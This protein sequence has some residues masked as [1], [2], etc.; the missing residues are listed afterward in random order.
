MTDEFALVLSQLHGLYS[1]KVTGEL[2]RRH[3]HSHDL[4]VYVRLGPRRCGPDRMLQCLTI[5]DVNVTGDQQQKGIF[6]RLLC[7]LEA[8]LPALGLHALVVENLSNPHLL[9]YLL[10]QGYQSTGLGETTVFKERGDM[11]TPEFCK[12][13][14]KALNDPG[15]GFLCWRRLDDGT[16]IALGRL[17][18]TVGLFVGV[19]PIT[20]YRRRY[21]FRDTTVALGEYNDMKTGDDVPSGWIARRPETLEDIEAKSKPNYDVSQF[22]PKKDNDNA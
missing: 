5:A 21:C 15:N 19:G 12:Q 20:P 9:R 6:S 13:T 18:T 3:I 1:H 4:H 8:E 16:Y 14:E 10:R 2:V 22:W 17:I 7:C 11:M